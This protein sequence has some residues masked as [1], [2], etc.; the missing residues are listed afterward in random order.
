MN[1]EGGTLDKCNTVRNGQLGQLVVL[2]SSI[3]DSF[4][5]SGQGEFGYPVVCK[6]SASNLGKAISQFDG[7]DA[8]VSKGA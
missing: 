4:G 8:T 7:F 6:C 5:R 2:E 1:C 3:T